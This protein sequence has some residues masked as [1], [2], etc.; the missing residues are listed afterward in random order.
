MTL[1]RTAALLL[2]AAASTSGCDGAPGDDMTPNAG[3][4]PP[5]LSMD[6]GLA[7]FLQD[8]PIDVGSSR[9]TVL[10]RLGEPDS[11]VARAV[12]NRHDPTVTDSV[13]ELYYDG[14]TAELY[15]AGY[16]G[17]EMLTGIVI[18]DAR[19]MTPLASVR[20]GSPAADLLAELGEPTESDAGVLRYLCDACL[21]SGHET[22]DFTIAGGSIRAIRI[23]YWIE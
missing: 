10:E 18:S 21:V 6:G 11:L 2:V 3:V 14:L 1:R 4:A 19:F 15:R 22:V 12:A 8:G 13:F 20:P 23:Q 7:A 16:D 17:K 5:A 9:S